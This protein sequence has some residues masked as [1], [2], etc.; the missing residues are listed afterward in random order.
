MKFSRTSSKTISQKHQKQKAFKQNLGRWCK[1]QQQN[2][3]QK[4]RTS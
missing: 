1:I 4:N 3:Q 2:N